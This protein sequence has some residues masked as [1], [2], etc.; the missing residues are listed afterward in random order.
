MVR[1][2]HSLFALKFDLFVPRI[3]GFERIFEALLEG[4]RFSA[5]DE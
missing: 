1:Q 3:E 4:L 5:G 2:P